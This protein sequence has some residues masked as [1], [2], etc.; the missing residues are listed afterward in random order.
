M[1]G[2]PY[3]AR[4]VRIEL[5]ADK[6]LHHLTGEPATLA[7]VTLAKD[8]ISVGCTDTTPEVL[9]HLLAE[10]RKRFPKND[11]FVLQEGKA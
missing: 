10:H 6:I 7:R 2:N 1:T 5:D 11:T 3:P 8:R 4:R 9:E